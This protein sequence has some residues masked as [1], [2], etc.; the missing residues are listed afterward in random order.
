M[1][2]FP[3]LNSS[4]TSFK[5]YH[6]QSNN[7]LNWLSP[8]G[9]LPKLSRVLHTTLKTKLLGTANLSIEKIYP[10]LIPMCNTRPK[11]PKLAAPIRK[12]RHTLRRSAVSPWILSSRKVKLC[13]SSALITTQSYKKFRRLFWVTRNGTIWSKGWDRK[14]TLANQPL[15]GLE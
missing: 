15:P 10:F 8:E 1:K 7:P 11:R 5:A 6:H 14:M 12:D 2:G 9:S 13:S 3:V 4:K